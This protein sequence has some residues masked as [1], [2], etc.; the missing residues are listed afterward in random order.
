MNITRR[1]EMEKSRGI[2][3]IALVISIVVLLILAGVSISVLTGDEGM[4][5]KAQ[6]AKEKT[7]IAQYEEQIKL[8]AIEAKNQKNFGLD[9]GS[10]K[11]QFIENLREKV[12]SN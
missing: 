1:K 5:T 8:L 7:Q 12:K 4:L 9:A 6:L 2:T 11:D 10:I 3:L